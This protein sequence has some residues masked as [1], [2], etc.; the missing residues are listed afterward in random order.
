[1][2][3]DPITRFKRWLVA[4]DIASEDEMMA[5]DAKVQEAVDASVEFARS[6]ADPRPEAGVENTYADGPAMATQFYNRKGLVT[7]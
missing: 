3:R 5:I 4:K 2:S 6:S 1:M 7:T